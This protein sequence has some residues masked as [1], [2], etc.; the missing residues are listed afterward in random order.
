MDNIITNNSI[1]D[2]LELS[3]EDCEVTNFEIVGNEKRL[4]IHKVNKPHFCPI[5][6]S[7]LHSKGIL[8]RYPNHQILRDGYKLVITAKSRRW[9]CSNNSCDYTETDIFSFIEPRK[10][11]TK[12]TDIQILYEMKDLRKSCSQLAKDYLV[13]DTYIHNLFMRYVDLPRKPLPEYMAVDEVHT[14]ISPKAKYALVI[15][16]FKNN[17]VID[18][19][20]S[21]RN[22]ITEQYF[23]SIPYDER[24]KVKYIICDMYK[25]YIKYV[26]R[27]FPNAIVITDSFHVIQWLLNL[28]NLYINEV[29]KKYQERDRRNLQNQNIYYGRFQKKPTLSNE[30][31][32]LNYAR[33]VLLKNEDNIDYSPPKRF[34]TKL[35]QYLDTYDWELKFLA[36]DNNFEEI[37]RLKE[38]YIFFNKSHINDLIGAAE[39]LDLLINEYS[40]SSINIFNEFS[41]LLIKYK[42]SIINSFIYITKDS[43]DSHFNELRRFSNGP[44]E[45]YNNKP[46]SYRSQS[47][48]IQNWD[49]T[50]NRL[51][52]AAR[53]DASLLAIPKSLDEIKNQTGIIRGP[54]KKK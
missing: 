13:S 20:K 26:T 48:G 45:S 36:L 37:R 43:S 38:K 35:N 9:T 29:K 8:T 39:D 46:S 11:N 4:T 31:Y 24:K 17:C 2:I 5:C 23:L 33:W 41:K 34:N 50:R 51:L 54:Y 27:F 32:I 30:V 49:F 15:M 12:L 25:P 16:D 42:E 21:R 44:I 28:I 47:H 10:K 40:A 7:R 19:L 52:W 22:Y 14:N 18:I 3:E 1:L 6:N 53:D